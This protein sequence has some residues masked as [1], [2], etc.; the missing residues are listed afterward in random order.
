MGREK[1]RLIEGYDRGWFSLKKDLV[2]DSCIDD[3]YLSAYITENG[4]PGICDYCL[5]D[6]DDADA[7]CV[8]FDHLMDVMCEAINELYES[9]DDGGIPYESAEGGYAFQEKVFDTYDLLEQIGLDAGSAVFKDVKDALPDQ[10]WCR[11]DFWSLS[12]GEALHS[13]WDQFV[14]KVKYETRYLFALPPR[15]QPAAVP[16]PPQPP[17]ENISVGTAE[18]LGLFEYVRPDEEWPA[19]E[20]ESGIDYDPDEGIPVSA[21]LDSIGRLIN[22]LDLIR[23]VDAGKEIFRVRVVDKGVNLSGAADL[24]PPTRERATQANRMSAPGIVMFSMAHSMPIKRCRRHLSRV[25]MERLGKT[26]G[27]PLLNCSRRFGLS[28]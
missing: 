11:K 4:V 1:D 25:G 20:S 23:E 5:P 26:S 18:A 3:S 16:A 15:R 12:L 7:L 2:C 13:G 6:S 10:F 17:A 14:E 9:A 19:A 27:S 24:G 21:M 8:P 22:R 28:T